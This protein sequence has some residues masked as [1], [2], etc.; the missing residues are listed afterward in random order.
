MLSNREKNT[1]SEAVAVCVDTPLFGWMPLRFTP[2]ADER[3]EIVAID[4]AIF[5]GTV[6]YRINLRARGGQLTGCSIDY[7]P[8]T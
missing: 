3:A 1:I 7:F 6:A 2:V 4:A 8:D 5:Y